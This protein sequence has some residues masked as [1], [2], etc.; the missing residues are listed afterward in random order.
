MDGLDTVSGIGY[1]V[2][3]YSKMG[4]GTLEQFGYIRYFDRKQSLKEQMDTYSSDE[5]SYLQLF[6]YWKENSRPDYFQKQRKNHYMEVINN[7]KSGQKP[8][9][10]V[11]ENLF[12]ENYFLY[13]NSSWLSPVKQLVDQI[14]N[15][16]PGVERTRLLEAFFEFDQQGAIFHKVDSLDFC[17]AGS[18]VNAYLFELIRTAPYSESS[19]NKINELL[20]KIL[21]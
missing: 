11:M 12:L 18:R 21:I 20:S 6:K 1:V 9:R 3:D 15:Q 16:L 7:L 14:V 8:S 4:W 19:P 17:D 2:I 10:T 13:P 5:N